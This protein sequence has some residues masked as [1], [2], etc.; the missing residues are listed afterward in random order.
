METIS[1]A[2]GIKNLHTAFSNMS[3]HAI[4]NGEI[5]NSYVKKTICTLSGLSTIILMGSVQAQSRLLVPV[6]LEPLPVQ[7]SPAASSTGSFAQSQQAL[8]P[9]R[10]TQEDITLE[11]QLGTAKNETM[12]AYKIALE[13][14]KNLPV[15]DQGVCIAQAKS[16]MEKEM[17]I[18]RNRFG[19]PN[20]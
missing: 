2:Q 7:T 15:P 1:H 14:C 3:N 16:E 11:E 13:E 10:W 17:G 8:E 20:P 6:P 18:I 4:L 5:L 19:L 9:E 12:A